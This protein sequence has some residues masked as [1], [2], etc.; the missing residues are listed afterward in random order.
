[1]SVGGDD[2]SSLRMNLRTVLFQGMVVVMGLHLQNAKE[3]A[4]KLVFGS[5]LR[6]GEWCFPASE[7][8]VRL[9]EEKE[10]R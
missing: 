10:E 7:V 9:Q 2:G 8:P 1:M 6:A 3:S 4:K 5:Y